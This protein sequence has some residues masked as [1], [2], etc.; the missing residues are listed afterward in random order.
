MKRSCWLYLLEEHAV[1]A[2]KIFT[3][4][5][6]LEDPQYQARE[7]LIDVEHPQ[8]DKLKMQ[9]VFPRLSATPGKVKWPGP[10]LGRHNDEVYGKLLG[11][12]DERIAALKKEKII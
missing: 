1:P 3:A 2:G 7:T 6:M 11:F 8:Y 10:E 5:D 4:A 9:S 12:S